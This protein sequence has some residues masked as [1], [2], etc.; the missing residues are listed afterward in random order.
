MTAPV[1]DFNPLQSTR[2]RFSCAS[3]VFFIAIVLYVSTLA[4]TVT[5]VDSGE[6]IVAARTLGV[7]HPPGFPLYVLLAHLATLLPIGN[8][9]ARVN[10]ASAL[11]AALAAAG[12]T[13]VVAEAMLTSTRL[14][15]R[16]DKSKKRDA[17]GKRSKK[18]APSIKDSDAAE[19]S[20]GFR[21]IIGSGSVFGCRVVVRLLAHALGIC[22]DSR[23]LHAEHAADSHY[24]S[25]DVPL[26]A[27]DHRRRI[28]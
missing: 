8:I 9:A 15:L 16:K 19:A 10:F 14:A 23:S 7:A 11:F 3:I 22:D 27:R 18:P 13:L 24:R 21:W 12:L 6:L 25:P 4:P 2:V 26:A 5:L 28:A 17:R 1:I 20:S